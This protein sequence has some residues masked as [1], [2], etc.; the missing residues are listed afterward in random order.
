MSV[1]KF[2]KEACDAQGLIRSSAVDVIE[3]MTEKELKQFWWDIMDREAAIAS[4]E[5]LEKKV[6]Q[7]TEEL[8]T[9]RDR[10]E[11]MQEY[12]KEQKRVLAATATKQLRFI[13][14]K[15]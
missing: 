3:A 13:T 15:R 7:L 6:K 14:E 8:E 5:F 11:E 10:N 9:L 12:I 1:E 4:K 2:L